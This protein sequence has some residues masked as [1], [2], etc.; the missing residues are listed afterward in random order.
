MI[1]FGLFA[2]GVIHLLP[3]SGVLGPDTL[4]KLYEIQLDAKDDHNLNVLMRHRAVLFGII[5]SHLCYASFEQSARPMAI[6]GGF[7]SVLSF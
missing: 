7:A 1:C 6:A 2:A 5:G 4:S 3:V